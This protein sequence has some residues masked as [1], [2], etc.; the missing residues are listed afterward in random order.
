[1]KITTTRY[2]ESSKV[3]SL[4]IKQEYCTDCDCEQYGNLLSR[5]QSAVDD[6]DVLR[7]AEQ[8]MAYSNTEKLMRQ[9]GCTKTELL[10]S[11]CFNLIN[12]CTY[13]TVELA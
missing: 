8:I 1:M 12:D 10:E 13:T 6:K 3:R 5:C 7:I 2:M 4:C 9:Y 11:I